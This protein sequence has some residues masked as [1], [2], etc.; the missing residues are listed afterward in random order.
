MKRESERN[1]NM[2]DAELCMFTSNLVVLMGRDAVEFLAKWIDAAAATAME[3]LGNAFEVF[4]NDA[5]FK[6]DI[7][8]YFK[9]VYWKLTEN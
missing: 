2:S 3:A 6:Y 5:Y 7:F 8:Y 1:Y 9:L 4:P